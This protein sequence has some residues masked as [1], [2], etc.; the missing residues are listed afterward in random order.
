MEELRT[1]LCNEVAKKKC[2]TDKKQKAVSPSQIELPVL[3]SDRIAS[4][5]NIKRTGDDIT[6]PHTK[7]PVPPVVIKQQ[8]R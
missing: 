8:W 3:K 6:S 1:V 2:I 5:K 4:S 7:M